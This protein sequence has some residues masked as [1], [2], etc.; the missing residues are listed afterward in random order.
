MIQ[1]KRP[2]YNDVKSFRGMPVEGAME[3]ALKEAEGRNEVATPTPSSASPVI[4]PVNFDPSKYV[5]HPSANLLVPVVQS[6][7]GFDYET[8][9]KKVYS[10]GYK[11]MT[12]KEF[13]DYFTGIKDASEG[14]LNLSYADGTQLNYTEALELWNFLSSTTRTRGNCWTWLNGMFK[15]EGIIKKHFVLETVTGIDGN[16]DLIVHP[17]KSE[18]CLNGDCYVKLEFNSQGLP[19]RKSNNQNYSQGENLYFYHPRENWV[20]GFYADSDRSSLSCN[21]SPSGSVAA[22]GVFACAEGASQNGGSP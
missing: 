21:G 19:V 4:T 9:M 18:D 8:T 1:D 6:Y 16:G 3:R 13:I 17:E 2:K 12:I 14:K 10:D 7:G 20:A 5:I 11:V 15:K 22:L